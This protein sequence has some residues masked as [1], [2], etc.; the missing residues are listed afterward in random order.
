MRR[1]STQEL[2]TAWEH[3]LNQ[4]SVQRALIL[5]AIAEPAAAPDE[6][7]R[8]TIGQRDARLLRLRE[9]LFG[10]RLTNVA[11][12]PACD[13]RIEWEHDVADV[14]VAEPDA[15]A[16]A[17]EFEVEYG[18]YRLA[19][20]L[21]NSSDV[22]SVLN[23]DGGKAQTALL[24]RCVLRAAAAGADT[25]V[26]DLPDRVVEALNRR[27]EALD[28]QANVRVGLTCPGCTHRWQI[29]FD[30]ASYLWAELGDWAERTLQTVHRLA[31]G[32]GWS[33]DDILGLSPVRRQ[34]YLGM[35]GP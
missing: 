7:A 32:Y 9:Q 29:L 15:G 17:G 18:G 35:L 10:A 21:P 1:P 16:P 26:E 12:C 19:C 33:E 2:L 24:S 11:T 3:G 8:L 23:G 20:R 5:L 31:H 27:F 28:P 14:R 30:I 13:E 6:L 4:P 25:R 34:M 22:A